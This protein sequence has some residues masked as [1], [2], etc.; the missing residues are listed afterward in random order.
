MSAIPSAENLISLGPRSNGI[1]SSAGASIFVSSPVAV[2]V[3]AKSVALTPTTPI[4]SDTSKLLTVSIAV[5]SDK[6]TESSV[7][8]PFTSVLPVLLIASVILL[9]LSFFELY[10][11]SLFRVLVFLKS[12][13]SVVTFL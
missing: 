7:T 4:T 12:D 13:D 3:T 9:V 11:T 8:L 10:V 6:P 1:A 2:S 5:D